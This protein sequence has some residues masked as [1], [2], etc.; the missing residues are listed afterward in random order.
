MSKYQYLFEQTNIATPGDIQLIEESKTEDGQVKAI[1]RCKLQTAEEK[2]QNRRYY[3]MNVC[4][5][6]VDQLSEKA[7]Q[8]SLLVEIDHPSFAS[9]DPNTIRKRAA[10]I[11]V[12]NCAALIRDIRL[13]G[14]DIIGEMETLSGFQGP[15]FARMLINDRV[16]IGFSLRALGAV[17]TQPDGTIIVGSPIKPITYDVVSN[18]SHASAR[19]L[20]FLP[21]SDSNIDFGNIDTSLIY[22]SEDL[23]AL[24]ADSIYLCEGGVC[25]VRFIDDL[26]EEKFSS[27]MKRVKFSLL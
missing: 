17:E 1:F 21:E 23:F 7:S 6:I 20:E 8:R 24:E 5:S 3:P 18:P 2:N 25:S 12:K 15:S 27:A 16:N 13:E 4:K 9:S 22:E 10:T 14:K 26:I 11:E 19:V